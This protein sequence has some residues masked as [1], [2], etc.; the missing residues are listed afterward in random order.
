[1]LQIPF[2][3]QNEIEDWFDVT[4]VGNLKLEIKGA[5]SVGTSHTAEIVLQQLR[6]Y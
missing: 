2:G 3:L 5:S 4:K 6:K 1:M